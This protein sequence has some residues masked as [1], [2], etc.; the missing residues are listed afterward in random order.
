[1][2][3]GFLFGEIDQTLTSAIRSSWNKASTRYWDPIQCLPICQ[4][5]PKYRLSMALKDGIAGLIVG[6]MVV[7]QVQFHQVAVEFLYRQGIAYASV[8]KLP[9]AYGLYAALPGALYC[10]FG[11]SKVRMHFQ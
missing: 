11:T 2:I 7:P 5:L 9:A 1:M 10:F 3:L 4:W 8:A 6:L